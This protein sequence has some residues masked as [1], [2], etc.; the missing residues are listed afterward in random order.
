[1]NEWLHLDAEAARRISPIHHI[2]ELGAPIVA[3]VGGDETPAFRQQTTDYVEAWRAAGH[4]ASVV[5]MPG[6]HH[7][8][9]M[10]E[11]HD[12]A[13]PLLAALLAMTRRARS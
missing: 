1:M 5:D 10:L 7:Y 9:L 6:H 4:D 8:S 3:A 2:P 13:S 11:L 12:P